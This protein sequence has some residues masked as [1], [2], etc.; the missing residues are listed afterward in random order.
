MMEVSVDLSSGMTVNLDRCVGDVP[1]LEIATGRAR[2]NVSVD[3]G[4][5]HD[6]DEGHVVLAN[7]LATAAAEF[8]DELRQIL[9]MRQR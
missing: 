8:R 6:I 2:L 9:A 5:V 7:E 1:V 3:V 4:D